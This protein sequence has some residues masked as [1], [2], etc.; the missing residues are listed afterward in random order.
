MSVA[1]PLSIIDLG[2]GTMVLMRFHLCLASGGLGKMFL[3]FCP[4]ILHSSFLFETD[5]FAKDGLCLLVWKM[6]LKTLSTKSHCGWNNGSSA[7]VETKVTSSTL[8]TS[9]DFAV[10]VTLSVHLRWFASFS[11]FMQRVGS[12]QTVFLNESASVGMMRCPWP[13]APAVFVCVVVGGIWASLG[14]S[15][16]SGAAFELTN[17]PCVTLSQSMAVSC[18]PFLTK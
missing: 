6:K 15:L 18:V 11:N 13:L 14:L 12:R 9:C 10:A 8:W 17:L 4:H 2:V 3:W 16:Q 1:F 5:M 7:T